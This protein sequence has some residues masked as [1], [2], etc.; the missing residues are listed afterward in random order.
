MGEKRFVRLPSFHFSDGALMSNVVSIM[1]LH[2]I[3][4]LINMLAPPW[5]LQ[6]KI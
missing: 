5:V 6:Q 3:D 4:S 2:S 1:F